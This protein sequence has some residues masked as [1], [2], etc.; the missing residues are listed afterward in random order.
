MHLSAH[1]DPNTG[2][3]F[4]NEA[5]KQQAVTVDG[6]KEVFKVH[7]EYVRCVVINSCAS[8]EFAEAIAQVID[9]VIGMS[10]AIKDHSAM[11]FSSAFYKTL[12]YRES[13][14][15]AFEAGIAE[16]VLQ[17][18]KGSHVP[19]LISPRKDPSKIYFLTND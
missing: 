13:V 11:V 7:K 3:L 19:M 17:N 6:L 18:Q 4:T 5:G 10:E 12:S 15:K 1:N 9:C 8:K 2:I 14:G 16:M